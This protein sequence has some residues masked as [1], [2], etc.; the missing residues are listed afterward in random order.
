MPST[1][2]PVERQIPA[3]LDSRR[4]VPAPPKRS[5]GAEIWQE[6]VRPFIIVLLAVSTFRSAVADWNDVPTGS[7]KPTILPGERIF[8]NKIA[9]DLKVPF[10]RFRL[11]QW[12]DPGRGD[13]V[14]LF[15][16][17]DDKRLVKRIVGLPGDR[18]EMRRNRLY[19]NGEEAEYSDYAPSD[20]DQLGFHPGPSMQLLAESVE[21]DQHPVL[22]VSYS[23][24]GSS[25]PEVVVPEGK[26]FV[27]GDNRNQSRDSRWFGFV[28]RERIVGQATTVVVSFDRER[29]FTPRWDRFFQE[30]P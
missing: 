28:D 19:V 2:V 16:P 21:E 30:L 27:M 25:F 26:Y 6:W 8:V 5:L 10:T 11:A 20:L 9:Y 24:V 23:P 29:S 22:W 13:V 12:D 7:M 3:S 1:P 4:P 17:A 15:S 18:I 14:V